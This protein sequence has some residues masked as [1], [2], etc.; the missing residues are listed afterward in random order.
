MSLPLVIGW[1][2]FSF[3]FGCFS[4]PCS[5]GGFGVPFVWAGF[6]FRFVPALCVSF[7]GQA[8]LAL[9]CCGFCLPLYVGMFRVLFILAGIASL[10]V[11][12][13]S[14]PLSFG[15]VSCKFV[16]AFVV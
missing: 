15:G 12:A 13:G 16:L 9:C 14:A 3:C 4:C 10:S 7:F 1:L 2:V 5:G 8:L 6:V 11:F